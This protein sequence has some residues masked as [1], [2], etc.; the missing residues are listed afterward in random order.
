MPRL[1]ACAPTVV[2]V[3]VAVVLASAVAVGVGVAAG[4]PSPGSWATAGPVDD[5]AADGAVVERPDD[6]EVNFTVELPTTVAANVTQEYSIDLSSANGSVNAT[7]TF[8]N[9]TKHGTTVEHSF[10]EGGNV[11]FTVTVTDESGASATREVTV[12]VVEY[13]SEDED[14]S[15]NPERF[16]GTVGV[17]FL[18]L[19]VFPAVT[20]LYLFPRAMEYLTDAFA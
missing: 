18:V 10:P 9:A 12:Q 6:D 17:I 14:A 4:T 13:G 15:M 11:T 5:T 2:I 3:L 19:G 8:P 7:W 1:D 20:L 16:F